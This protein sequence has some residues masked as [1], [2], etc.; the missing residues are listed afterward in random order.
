MMA[1]F[2]FF[3]CVDINMMDSS[4]DFFRE[5]KPAGDETG[6]MTKETCCPAASSS[7]QSHARLDLTF[8]GKKQQHIYIKS[9]PPPCR[10]YK[11]VKNAQQNTVKDAVARFEIVERCKV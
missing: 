6:K 11:A 3:C 2:F 10:P 5:K 4:Q 1:I 9:L 8:S 7:Q